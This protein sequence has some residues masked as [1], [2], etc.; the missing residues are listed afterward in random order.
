MKNL[1]LASLIACSLFSLSFDERT[2]N[3]SYALDEENSVVE[4]NGATAKVSHQGSFSVRSQGI[5]VVDGKIKGGTFVIPIA[6]I[7]NF[8]LPKAVKPILLKHLKSKDFFNIALY[9]EASF[10]ITEVNSLDS[11]P[12]GA[13]EGANA[14]VV[15]DFTM[16]GNTHSLSFPARIKFEREYLAVEAF[17][18]IDRTKWGMK[19]ATNPEKEKHYIYPEVDIHLKVLSYQK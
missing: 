16:I 3:F 11:L 12:K 1:V 6:S 9:P 14:M 15:G 8:D 7:K 4:W 17:F 19:Y 2:D 18:Q 13:V 5:D 10:T